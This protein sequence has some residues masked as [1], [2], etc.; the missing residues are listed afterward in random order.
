MATSKWV[1]DNSHSEIQFKIR[2]LMITNV[3]GSFQDFSSS[4]ETEG[5]DF[6]KAKIVFS[7]KI[8]SINTGNEQR[9]GHLKS[10]D[11]FDAEKYPEVVFEANGLTKK[12]DDEYEVEGN[13]TLHGVTKKIKLSVEAGGV[14]KDSYGQT[15]AGFSVSA[16]ISRK[17]FGLNWNAATE[18]GGVV[19]SDEVKVNAEVQ[20]VKQ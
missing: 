19:V 1:I 20:Y 18:T 10:A 2:H 16:K 8:D 14:V 11:F 6:T 17:E 7:A 9:D 4:V 3:T 5:D 12:G 13:L 15:K